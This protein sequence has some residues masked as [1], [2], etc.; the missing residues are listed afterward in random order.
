MRQGY[1]ARVG[2]VDVEIP[3]AG[4]TTRGCGC[5][6]PD[7]APRLLDRAL[8]LAPQH[9]APLMV[10]H[11]H[12]PRVPDEHGPGDTGRHDDRQRAEIQLCLEHLRSHRPDVS[13]DVMVQHGAPEDVLTSIA[14]SMGILVL[15]RRD[16]DHPVYEHLGSLTRR[17]L[18]SAQMPLVVVPRPLDQV[19]TR[20]R[21]EP[22]PQQSTTAVV[23]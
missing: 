21:P 17:M 13:V 12:D 10:V 19:V 2:G 11:V 22:A 23:D 14:G 4:A 5:G 6:C 3:D 20:A 16:T 9:H 18:Q 7:A 1:T 8:E 15:G